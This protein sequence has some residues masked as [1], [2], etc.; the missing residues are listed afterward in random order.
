MSIDI[1][2]RNAVARIAVSGVSYWFDRPYSY[3]VPEKFRSQL[4]PGMRVVVPF[5]GSRPREG[6]VLAMGGSAERELKSVMDLLDSEP[7]LTEAQ[8]RLALWMRERFFCTV[9]EAAKTILPAGLW[10][11]ISPSYAL[12][13]GLGRE[14]ALA[15]AGKSKQETLVLDAVFQHEGPC[16]LSDIE[17]LFGSKNPG[18]ALSSLVRKGILQTEAVKNRR[19][20]D[21]SI[22]RVRLSVSR[23]E[24]LSA[25]EANPRAIRQ[26]AV[27]RVLCDLEAASV[28]DI[29][30][31][32]GAGRDAIRRLE[33]KRLVESFEEEYFRRP[34]YARG[35]AAP[36][37][38]LNHEQQE[39]FEGILAL[40]E[41]DKAAAALLL[42]VTG[43]GKTTVYIRLIHEILQKGKSAILLVP[44]I[45]LT[46]QMLRSFSSHFG[47]NIAV[48]HSA[49]SMGE[50][51]DEWKRIRNG[52]ARLVIGTRSAIFAPVSD[53]GIVI[54]DEEQED[55]YKS[56]NAS[57]YHARDVAKYLCVRSGAVLLL[58]S[59]TPD[60]VSRY[61]AEIGKYKL[62]TLPKRYNAMQLPRVRV[63]DM[64]Q[65]LRA[66]NGGVISSLLRHELQ[67]NLDRGEQ[68]ILFL[69][70]RGTNKLVT[71]GECGFSYQCPNCSCSLTY[72]SHGNRLLCH[73]CG[74]SQTPDRSCPDC[75]GKFSYV[76]AG[77]QKVVEELQALFPGTPVLRMDTDSVSPAQSHGT[78]LEKFRTQ[79]I[80][81]MVGTQMVTKGLNFENATLV[82][83]LSADQ[84]LYAGDYRAAERSFSLITQ[85]IGRS[86]RFEKPGRAVIQTFTPDNQ[87]I[88]LAA[89]QDYESFYRAELEIRRL[90][91]SPPF[92]DLFVL[93]ASGQD[94]SAVLRCC[95]DLRVLLLRETATLP[96]T[97]VLGPAPMPIARLNNTWRYRI[98]VLSAAAA[99]VR[100]IVSAA[101]LAC[102][103][104]KKYRGVSVYADFNPLN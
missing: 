48:L 8:L 18:P 16:P 28:A 11:K 104:D 95:A 25:I 85:V 68:S 59:A 37:P 30:Y 45:A 86:G 77:T 70:R 2:D 21:R 1:M 12:A 35:S 23:D 10:Y 53:L 73:Y 40:T 64:K 13:E 72:H 43:S 38:Q 88:R 56:E 93:T 87:V 17:A 15:A 65:E 61:S 20:S 41:Q 26:A 36:L 29:C 47:E 100:P 6:L 19:G 33:D 71:C 57:R 42:G 7:L 60:I 31:F 34:D 84:S 46:P 90:S 92:S 75:G 24:A 66:G 94:E 99:S 82:G 22:R 5:G 78:L 51:Y 32:T 89:A 27:L 49:L 91:G 101:L 83:V 97:A 102:N 74:H 3:A 103:N 63:V 67:E 98:T 76:G 9:T 4:R 81:I 80:P 52:D 69:N 50:R 44:E 54:I 62:F 39:A 14:E 58:G 96:D 55:T 79:R